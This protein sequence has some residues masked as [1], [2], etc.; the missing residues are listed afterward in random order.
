MESSNSQTPIII[1]TGSNKGIGYGIVEKLLEEQ[2]NFKIIMTSRKLEN[3]Q[4]TI[5][6]LKLR[7]PDAENIHLFQLDLLDQKSI[8][9]FVEDI[10]KDFSN[11]IDI[12]LNNAGVFFRGPT[13]SQVVDLTMNTN[14]IK[15]KELTE[16]FLENNL[17]RKNGKIINISSG[18]GK[19]SKL[20]NRNPEVHNYL[21]DYKINQEITIE[22]IDEIALNTIVEMK[23]SKLCQKWPGSVYAL[24][25]LYLSI[26]TF[27]LSKQK[28]IV[29]RGIQVYSC[30]PG[31]CQTD[32]TK[33]TNAPK[34]IQEGS[35]TPFFL[36]CLPFGIDE[37]KQGLFF[38]E[39]KIESL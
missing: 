8:E 34:T 39:G 22:K 27:I 11:G 38:S 10:K 16:I 14:Y 32:L 4:A 7:F 1:I 13:T 2:K 31:W 23:D 33:G 12:L 29:D 3:G 21:K 25:K 19:L 37:G 36:A 6:N 28:F 15:T 35:E 20:K 5:E 26:W 18:L 17:I 30:C 24:S 9:N